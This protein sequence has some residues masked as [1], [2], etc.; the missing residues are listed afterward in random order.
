MTESIFQFIALIDVQ[1]GAVCPWLPDLVQK[2]LP[3]ASWSVSFMEDKWTPKNYL[4]SDTVDPNSYFANMLWCF[5]T[6]A[7]RR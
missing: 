7:N 1:F 3:Q 4:V 6:E 5:Q 2:G